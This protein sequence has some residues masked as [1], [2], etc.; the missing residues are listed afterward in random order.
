MI[1]CIEKSLNLVLVVTWGTLT[2]ELGVVVEEVGVDLV[3][4][5]RLFHNELLHKHKEGRRDPIYEGTRGPCVGEREMQEL[6]HLEE[7]TETIHEPM[8]IFFSDA[9]L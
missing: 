2:V 5:P 3:E 1:L 9:S 6:Q 8:L 7:G 4:D